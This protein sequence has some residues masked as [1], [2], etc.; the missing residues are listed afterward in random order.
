M[1]GHLQAGGRTFGYEAT[2]FRFSHV[3]LNGAPP[4]SPAVT[5]YRGDIAVTDEAENRFFQKITY[6]FPQSATLSSS[7]LRVKVGTIDLSGNSPHRM[8]L[9]AALR[10]ASFDLHLASKRPAMD[11]GGRGYLR[12][13][14]G[15]TYYYSL[16][17]VATSGTL[18]IG[19]R[20]YRVRGTSWLDHQWGNWSWN[21]IRGWTWMALQLD[22][23]RQ[24]SLFDFHDGGKRTR[25]ASL[26]MPDG[27]TRTITRLGISSSG[28]WRSPHTGAVYPS[29]WT[30]RIP[31]E[32]ADLRITPSVLDQELVA[33]SQPRGSY[34]EG[35]G[36]VTGTFL[37]K[38]VTGMS[39]TE[40]T[41]FAK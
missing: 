8:M 14:N 3:H 1:V 37:G 12:F 6:Y 29:G 21:S 18:H 41:G 40:L 38:P 36:R 17:D 25:V 5:L 34:W 9:R 24:L 20:T 26:L 32:R 7:T 16:T 15:Y 10:N 35:S 13:G 4:G 31:A 22:D 27:S 19:A 39:Y 11:V 2:A 23:G 28:E 30:V 33:P